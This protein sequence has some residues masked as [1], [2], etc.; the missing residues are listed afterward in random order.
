ML[1]YSRLRSRCNQDSPSPG[2]WSSLLVLRFEGSVVI[3]LAWDPYH[4][5]PEKGRFLGVQVGL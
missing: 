5:F 4:D 2:V 1:L 3:G